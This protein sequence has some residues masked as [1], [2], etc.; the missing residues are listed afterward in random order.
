MIRAARRL[1]LRAGHWQ[2]PTMVPPIRLRAHGAA[3]LIALTATCVLA[4]PAGAATKPYSVVISPG[5]TVPGATVAFQ[6]KFTN[7][8]TNQ[9]LGSANL[10]APAGFS[11]LGASVRGQTQTVSQNIVE[12]RNL[13]VAPGASVIAT[14][15]AGVPSSN[16]CAP[17]DFTWQ[18]VAKQS[19]DFNGLPGNDFGPLVDS[20]LTTS[21]T[22]DGAATQCS[23]ASCLGTLNDADASISVSVPGSSGLLTI[24]RGNGLDCAGYDEILHQDF[25]VDFMP[26]PGTTGGTKIVTITIT[27]A[28]MH[29]SANNG[30]AQVNM[31]F[32]A[33]F[34][35]AVKPGTPALQPSGA[36]VFRGLL[37]DC[38]TPPCVADRQSVGG[39]ARIVVRAP[40]GDQD[41]R[42]GP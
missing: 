40:G 3:L 6:A 5:T 26:D 42:Y 41:P 15:T 32:E 2:Y 22:C 23:P 30:L 39:G 13:G 35:F 18:V 19:N 14:V 25:A 9:M 27:K 17:A 16:P 24:N 34:T 11:V 29:A 12:L 1:D 8:T 7:R 4:A 10:T 20:R 37:P 33:P 36:G 21:T 28:A 38:G 31:C